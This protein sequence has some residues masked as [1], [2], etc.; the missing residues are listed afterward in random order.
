M[1]AVFHRTSSD[2]KYALPCNANLKNYSAPIMNINEGCMFIS[3]MGMF[4]YSKHPHIRTLISGFRLIMF[5]FYGCLVRN[6]PES[7]LKLFLNLFQK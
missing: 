4:D 7:D 2:V 3:W 5:L 1:Y 6:Q